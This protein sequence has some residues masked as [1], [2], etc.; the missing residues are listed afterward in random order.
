MDYKT[1]LAKVVELTQKAKNPGTQPIYPAAIN[2]PA[3]Q[4]LYDNLSDEALAACEPPPVYG[5]AASGDD[6]TDRAMALD[7]SIRNVKKANWRGNKFKEKE[8]RI[9][10]K[11]VLGDDDRL[12]D[13]IFGIVTHQNEY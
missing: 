2:R 6:R 10:I 13:A 5:P 3:L 1:Y 11:S 4:A 12:V 8:I 9:A 7:Q